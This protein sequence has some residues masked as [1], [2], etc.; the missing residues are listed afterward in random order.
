[1]GVVWIAGVGAS[2]GLGAAVARR[3]A[4]EGLRAVLT[5]RTTARLEQVAAEI[6]DAGGTAYPMPGDVGEERD[7]IAIAKKIADDIGPLE[8]AVFNAGSAVWAPSLELTVDD[9][10]TAL[11]INTLGGFIFGREAVR[12]MAPYERGSLLYTGATASL[13]GKPPFTAFAAAKAGL[14]SISQSFAREFGPR[15]IHV[16][17]VVIDGAI[18]GERARQRDP[19]RAE[20]SPDSLLHP[21][22]IADVY[23]H[24]HT[25]PRSTWTQE[26]DLRPFK[27]T[28]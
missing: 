24:L 28:F 1:L 18:D 11:R 15:G 16:A 4:R 25:Q 6:H 5:G 12:V 20:L 7:M 10:Q 8:A 27:E 23:W 2:V 19:K 17:H 3:F 21:D 13:R 14:R 26:I 22:E 9:V